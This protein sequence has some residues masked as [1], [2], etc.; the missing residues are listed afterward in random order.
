MKPNSTINPEKGR[1]I[2]YSE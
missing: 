2:W 1:K